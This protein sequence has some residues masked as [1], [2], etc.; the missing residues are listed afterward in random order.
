MNFNSPN[1]GVKLGGNTSPMDF[2]GLPGMVPSKAVN[3][4]KAYRVRYQKFN[5]DDLADIAE[6]ERIETKALRDE[7]IYLVNSK[8]FI[9]MD[10][11]FVLVKYYE[12]VPD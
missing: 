12:L 7:G 9:F 11:I 8:D 6:L 5:L 4:L 2:A 1:E 10:K 3:V